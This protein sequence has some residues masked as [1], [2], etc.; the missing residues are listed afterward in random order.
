MWPNQRA[1]Q[2]GEVEIRVVHVGPGSPNGLD[3]NSQAGSAPRVPQ[4]QLPAQAAGGNSQGQ[5]QAPLP[6]RQ[7]RPQGAGQGQTQSQDQRHQNGIPNF[8]PGSPVISA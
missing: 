1:P 5:G 2:E 7:A 3:Q 8:L 6:R 4:P